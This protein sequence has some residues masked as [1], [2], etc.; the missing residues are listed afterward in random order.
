MRQ[1]IIKKSNGTKSNGT[2][3]N[4]TKSIEKKRM[5]IMITKLMAISFLVLSLVALSLVACGGN[6]PTGGGETT[7]ASTAATAAATTAAAAV[8]TE[9]ATEQ[10]ADSTTAAQTQDA[11][12][13]ATAAT[14]AATTTQ[15]QTEVVTSPAALTAANA[16]EKDFSNRI[17]VSWTEVIEGDEGADYTQD[18]VYQYFLDSFNL[19][20]EI[21]PLTWGNW[22]ENLRIWINSGDMPDVA[23]WYYNH[24]EFV[25]Y[26]DQG[27]VRGFTDG[28][29]D[30]WPNAAKLFDMTGIG[31]ELEKLHGNAY[32]Y[33]VAIYFNNKPA[34]ILG[35]HI[36]TYIRKD[37]IEAVGY[38][39]KE[40]YTID[41][42]IEIA[43]AM[44]EQDPGG[45]GANFYPITSYPNM[46]MN[47]LPYSMYN[48]SAESAVF[49][50]GSDGKYKWGPADNET[51]EALQVFQD[52]YKEGLI[53]PE[54]YTLRQGEDED[55]MTIAGTSAMFWAGGLANNY[56]LFSN[57]MIENTDLNP[58]DALLST[59]I[60]G[61]DGKY[62]SQEVANYF[63]ALLF[64]P[65][66]SDEAFERVM[67]AVDFSTTVEGQYLTHLG[68][69]GEDY[70]INPDGSLD[71]IGDTEPWG[72][73]PSILFFQTFATRGDDFSIV[74]PSIPQAY[75]EKQKQQYLT[76][77][78]LADSVSLAPLDWTVVFHTSPAR[79]QVGFT[80]PDEYVQ[81]IL[82]EGD[83]YT[84]WQ[85]WVNEKMPLVQVVLDELDALN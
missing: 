58:D 68:F 3:S 21:T 15:A 28:W 64:S 48:H 29:R 13:A 11:T 46:I 61:K 74:D 79:N 25:D 62:Q 38:E 22:M 66:L 23:N 60:V 55:M 50:K 31:P 83:L 36:Q 72:K 81:L 71:R 20:I 12:T 7:A 76:K 54:F 78:S 52:A 43:R 27:M 84:N 40:Y 53:H 32:A 33:P 34:D 14:E 77:Y 85:N 45:V 63:G 17:K 65:S 8:A 9:A 19:E 1:S 16:D 10:G 5:N 2:K 73:Y 39:A 44:K 67:D 69:E 51:Y 56:R 82:R 75:R 6:S 4:C 57:E 80:Y 35:S 41:E 30:K 70:T 26:V 24:N 42:L 47:F 59:F 49:Y 37:W 18:A